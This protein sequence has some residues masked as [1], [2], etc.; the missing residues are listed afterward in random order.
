MKKQGYYKEAFSALKP[1]EQPSPELAT[2]MICTLIQSSDA[3][4]N[5]YAKVL[6]DKLS[7]DGESVK[8]FVVKEVM[9]GKG[10]NEKD[11]RMMKVADIDPASLHDDAVKELDSLLYLVTRRDGA[12]RSVGDVVQ[13]KKTFGISEDE[14]AEALRGLYGK[15]G[16]DIGDD[17]MR[18]LGFVKE[19]NG[20][21][22]WAWEKP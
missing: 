9:D 4:F 7:F 8:K 22:L 10:I 13:W 20:R 14:Y 21:T 16:R 15:Q 18:A 17:N 12:V 19:E 1:G 11:L 6:M 5:D 3:E 2:K